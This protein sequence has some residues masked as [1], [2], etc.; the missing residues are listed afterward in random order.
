MFVYLL[1]QELLSL[2]YDE[3]DYEG[4]PFDFHGG[5]IGYIGYASIEF[6][7]SKYHIYVSSCNGSSLTSILLLSTLDLMFL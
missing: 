4:L 3:K 2:S 1:F 5:Y 6:K 7:F